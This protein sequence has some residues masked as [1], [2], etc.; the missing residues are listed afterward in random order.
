[1]SYTGRIVIG[2]RDCDMYGHWKPSAILEAMQE[3]AI[4]HCASIDLGRSVTDG[5]GVFWVLSRCGVELTR[6]PAYGEEI[7]IET[8][9]MPIKHLFFPRAHIFYGQDGAVI[10]G[11]QSL[12]MLMEASTR[13][14]VKQPY[15]AE[16]MPIEDRPVPAAPP[17][18]VRLP[19]GPV[20]AGS[21]NP[22]FV[23]FDMNGHV[24]NVKYLDWCWNA[25]GFE[26]LKGRS[27]RRF[28][29]NYDRAILPGEAVETALHLEDGGFSFTGQSDGRRCFGV[30]GE[31]RTDR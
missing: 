14:A 30:S 5:L 21:V 1:M 19:E 11:A 25:L 13:R 23:E 18:T 2:T 29:I 9:A 17:R 8:F 28:D 27:L 26:A 6:L 7:A 10:G 15:V 12:W 22:Q 31:L 20:Q 4:A 24:N 16:R 3:T